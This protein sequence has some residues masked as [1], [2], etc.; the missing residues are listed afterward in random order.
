MSVLLQ[1]TTKIVNCL[2]VNQR[3]VFLEE[4]RSNPDCSCILTSLVKICLNRNYRS[5]VGF[6][7]LIQS[8]WFLAGHLFHKRLET[9]LTNEFSD[10]SSIGDSINQINN[11][12]NY[13]TNKVNNN[14]I[15][16][17]FLLFLDCVFQLTIQYPNEFEFNEIYLIHMWDYS[18]SSASLTFSFDGI[19][20]LQNYIDTQLFTASANIPLDSEGKEI[21][22]QKLFN[23]NNSFWL[24]HLDKNRDSL[25][26]NKNYEPNSLILIPI[27]KAYMLKFWSRCY[28]RWH[29]KYHAYNSELFNVTKLKTNIEE[30]K[31]PILKTHSRP[32]P[33][34]PTTPNSNNCNQLV[35]SP[36]SISSSK[37]TV[38]SSGL[39]ITTRITEDGHIESSF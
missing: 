1:L 30:I 12:P 25:L 38:S 10:E 4:Y 36:S 15:A 35:K 5:I 16:P 33:P 20:S 26:C 7:N 22:L 34:P 21:F 13:T 14:Q 24:N 18:C 8:D 19:I 28:L 2:H 11:T 31:Q 17:A 9:S 23:A 29:E 37:V 32:A 39:K 3:N 27:D 6:E